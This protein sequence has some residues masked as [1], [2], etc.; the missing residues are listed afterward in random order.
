MPPRDQ[1]LAESKGQLTLALRNANDSELSHTRPVDV[2]IFDNPNIAS[3]LENETTQDV[4]EFITSVEGDDPLEEITEVVVEEPPKWEI[5]IYEGNQVR[6]EEVELPEEESGTGMQSSF[7][8]PDDRDN[9][10]HLKNWLKRF[11]N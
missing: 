4:E 8:G 7:L 1:V 6:V 2:T 3:G 11:L 9:Q 10:N 5:K